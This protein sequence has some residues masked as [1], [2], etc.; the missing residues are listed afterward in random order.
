MS[1]YEYY[2]CECG[3]WHGVGVQCAIGKRKA[4]SQHRR[5]R[6]PA[7][8]WRSATL[9]LAVKGRLS[10][11]SKDE[12][13]WAR[14]DG[15]GTYSIEKMKRKPSGILKEGLTC[16]NEMCGVPRRALKLHN[17]WRSNNRI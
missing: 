9:K 12:V 10:R 4:H 7:R 13:V 5:V 8:E 14:Y 6:A 16:C 17:V 11:W 15:H 2:E 1:D 3:R